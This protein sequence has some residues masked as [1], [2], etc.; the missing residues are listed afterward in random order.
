MSEV[1][2]DKKIEIDGKIFEDVLTAT[3]NEDGSISFI[4]SE[5]THI[6]TISVKEK[7]MTISEEKISKKEKN[8]LEEFFEGLK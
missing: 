6:Y 8:L 2:D 5:V 7:K 3:K 4:N 1:N